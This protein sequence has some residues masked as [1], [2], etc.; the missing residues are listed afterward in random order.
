METR[1]NPT[2]FQYL[3]IQASITAC[4]NS[5]GKHIYLYETTSEGKARKGVI[6]EKRVQNLRFYISEIEKMLAE[7]PFTKFDDASIKLRRGVE[8]AIDEYIFNNQTPTKLSNKNSRINWEALKQI[9]TDE[10]LIEGLRQIHGRASG[11]EL[12]NGFEREENPL[13]RDGIE[14]LC[15]EL[16]KLCSIAQINTDREIGICNDRQT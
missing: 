1:E 13:D 16:K 3:Q 14:E 15:N 6:V 12:H 8:T 5:K 9:H 4:N 7:T 2:V 11:G 10:E